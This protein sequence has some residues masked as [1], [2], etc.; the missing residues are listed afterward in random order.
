MAVGLR[1]PGTEALAVLLFPAFGH[2][3]VALDSGLRGNEAWLSSLRGSHLP[4][5]SFRG[6]F[7]GSG[8]ETRCRT[9]IEGAD[10]AAG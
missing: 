10:I 6:D 2:G 3:E 8:E 7:Q 4:G 1:W 5:S 9:A